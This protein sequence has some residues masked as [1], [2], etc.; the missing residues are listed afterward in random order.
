MA[1]G[2][3]VD[4]RQ[5]AD[6]RSQVE[7]LAAPHDAPPA[8][9]LGAKP[10][11][12]AARYAEEIRRALDW[13]AGTWAACEARMDAYD[14]VLNSWSARAPMPG[15]LAGHVAVAFENKIYIHT[16]GPA[17]TIAPSMPALVAI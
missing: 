14:P 3:G 4:H 15:P 1:F 5:R 12:K 17:D 11:A 2:E 7:G 10:E 6:A 9:Q 8:E 16:T 13:Q